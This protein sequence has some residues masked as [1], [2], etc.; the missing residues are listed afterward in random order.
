MSVVHITLERVG[1]CA[2][3]ATDEQGNRVRVAGSAELAQ[4]ILERVP[5]PSVFSEPAPLEP[6]APGFRP[7]ALF[8]VSLAGCSAMDL[9][10]ILARQRQDVRG[11]RIEVEGRRA[12]ATPAVYEHITLRFLAEGPVNP[13]ALARAADLAVTKYC[14]VAGMLK[15]EVQVQVLTG[16]QT[17]A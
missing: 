2:Y 14:S 15:P 8:L 3:D 6:G 11:L 5:D 10:L 7:M 12:E 16:G 9:G 1:P 13:E 17:P 4:Q